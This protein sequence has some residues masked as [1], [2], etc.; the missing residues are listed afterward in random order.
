L[1]A[2][3]RKREGGSDSSLLFNN[4]HLSTQLEFGGS[5]DEKS[6]DL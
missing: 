3:L 1:E 5:V 2:E 6:G 4:S